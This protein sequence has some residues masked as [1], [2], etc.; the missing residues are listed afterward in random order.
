VVLLELKPFLA[1]YPWGH[2]TQIATWLHR[3]DIGPVAEAW[4][5]THPAGPTGIS[6]GDSLAEVIA[7]NPEYYLGPGVA[8]LPWLVK[9]LAAAAPLSLQVHPD[10]R[11]AAIRF[12]TGHKSYRDPFPKP[13]VLVALMPTTALIGFEDDDTARER[14]TIL[15]LPEMLALLARGSAAAAV[16]VWCDP[17]LGARLAAALTHVPTE[18][19]GHLAPLVARW[20][21]DPGLAVACFLRPV[22]LAPGQAVEIPAGLIHAYLSGGGIEVMG[23]SDNVLRGGLTDKPVDVTELLGVLDPAAQAGLIAVPPSGALSTIHLPACISRHC[24]PNPLAVHG[25]AVVW[26]QEAAIR[27]DFSPS[28]DYVLTAGRAIFVPA[29]LGPVE[30]RGGTGWVVTNPPVGRR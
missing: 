1:R 11:T 27:L 23:S 15:A 19:L 18:R 4:F 14:A 22:C 13:E 2:P 30:L 24:G 8:T 25:P 16:R 10:A 7:S 9:L 21:R 28:S 20:P 3:T 6:T 29:A 26:C 12:A 5:G 17:E